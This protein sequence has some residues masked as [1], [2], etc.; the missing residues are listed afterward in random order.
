MN[1]CPIGRNYPYFDASLLEVYTQTR[2]RQPAVPFA[3]GYVALASLLA[4]LSARTL[5]SHREVHAL[6]YQLV[7]GDFK[8]GTL[9]C[10]ESQPEPFSISRLLA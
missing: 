3:Y 1:K 6:H 10:G 2:A 5:G 9:N 4:G 8:A 7:V